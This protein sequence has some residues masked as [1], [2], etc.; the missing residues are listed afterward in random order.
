MQKRNIAMLNC[1]TDQSQAGPHARPLLPG[2]RKFCK[3]NQKGPG[4]LVAVQA[5]NLAKMVLEQISKQFCL[6]TA[7]QEQFGQKINL[8]GCELGLI[9][10]CFLCKV[11]PLKNTHMTIQ[12][13]SAY[14][15]ICFLKLAGKPR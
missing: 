1:G 12:N 14:C 9:V 8:L 7:F 6:S 13:F 10:K 3:I 11:N 15:R 5:R 4:I 2:G